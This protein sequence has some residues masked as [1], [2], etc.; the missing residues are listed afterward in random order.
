M[1]LRGMPIN[2]RHTADCG[3]LSGTMV[4]EH[5]QHASSNVEGLAGYAFMTPLRNSCAVCGDM[6]PWQCN[7]KHCWTLLPCHTRLVCSC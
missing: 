7:D 4:Q 2:G 1:D 6:V 3:N 5:G